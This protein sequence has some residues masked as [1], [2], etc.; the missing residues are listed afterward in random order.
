M[1]GHP[2]E[3]DAQAGLMT[4]VDEKLEV[5]GR[6][7][8]ARRREEPEHLIAPGARE[9]ML[10]HR[11]Q[12]DVGEAH[13]LHV[14]HEPVRH[15][16][17]GEETGC[18]LPAPAPTIRDALRRS[19]SGGRASRR[20]R[21]APP[22]TPGRA[23]GSPRCRGRSTPTAAALRTRSRT[24]RSSSAAR[25]CGRGS[26][27]CISRR[28]ARSGMKISQMPAGTS[29]RIGCTRPSHPLKSPTRLTR[30]ALGAHTAKC[31]PVVEPTAIRCAPS[32]SNAR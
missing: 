22:S 5:L 12:L 8:A 2:V 30:S 32:F 6:P 1:P 14:R 3:N 25:R 4:G 28:P 27:T 20:A 16:A 31:T 19:P 10:H 17:I 24:D 15:L 9:R 13:L 11:Q 26:R 23:T 7:E 21:A 29:S 18:L